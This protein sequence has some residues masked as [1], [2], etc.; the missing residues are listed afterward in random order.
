[1]DC[2]VDRDKCLPRAFA[3]PGHWCWF[4]AVLQALASIHDPRPLFCIFFLCSMTSSSKFRTV[5]GKRYKQ[6]QKN[7]PNIS[8]PGQ[9]PGTNLR[10][11]TFKRCQIKSNKYIII[12]PNMAKSFESRFSSTIGVLQ[13]HCFASHKTLAAKNRCL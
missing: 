1:M 10:Y 11:L 8:C 7:H 5:C 9:A 12:Y 2:P 6:I 4:N 3:N 13:L